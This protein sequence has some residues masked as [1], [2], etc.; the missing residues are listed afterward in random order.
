MTYGLWSRASFVFLVCIFFPSKAAMMAEESNTHTFSLL[1]QKL[2]LQA[3]LEQKL[4]TDL[5]T[6]LHPINVVLLHGGD[7]LY[8]SLGKKSAWEIARNAEIEYSD[9]TI[10][11][12]SYFERE[13]QLIVHK[14][15]RF[16]A[17]EIGRIFMVHVSP[18]K[19]PVLVEKQIESQS[20]CL[21]L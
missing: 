15:M 3:I 20:I 19:E 13:A 12:S 10:K 11:A 21:L 5:P 16:C 6:Q 7:P 14:R 9:I 2:T 17:Q 4:Y 1:L 18:K 8:K